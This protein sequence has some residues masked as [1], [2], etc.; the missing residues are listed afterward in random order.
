MESLTGLMLFYAIMVFMIY[1][2][3]KT[4]YFQLMMLSCLVNVALVTAIS[5]PR[6]QRGQIQ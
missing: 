3:Y 6:K 2:H 5:L 4:D 1:E